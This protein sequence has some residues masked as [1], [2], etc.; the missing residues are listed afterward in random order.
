MLSPFSSEWMPIFGAIDNHTMSN[1]YPPG[2]FRAS[3]RV[4]SQFI[5][6]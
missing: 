2:G 6:E 5:T 3:G 1:E 4:E